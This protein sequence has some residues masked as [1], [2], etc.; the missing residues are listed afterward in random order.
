MSDDESIL[1]LC[2]RGRPEGFAR[3]LLAYQKRVYQRAYSF[4][5]HRE[6][7]LDLTQEVFLRSIRGMP[8]FTPGRPLW[9]WLRR[10]TTNVCLNHLRSKPALLSL[11]QAWERGEEPAGGED[12]AEA[13]VVAWNREQLQA[14]LERLPPLHRMAVIL[15]HQEGLSY[16]EVAR[17]MDLPLGTVKTYLFRA[18]QKLR[19]ELSAQG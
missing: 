7:A 8:S 13:A 10:I 3:L 19:I 9:P 1:D 14:A 6:D 12:P 2:Q 18:R 11:D 5:R 4:V 15:R 17:G 16:D